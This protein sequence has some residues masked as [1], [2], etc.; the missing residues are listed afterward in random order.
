MRNKPVSQETLDLAKAA[1]LRD[2]PMSQSS[3]GA[4]AGSYLHLV[5][6]DLPLDTPAKA[7]QATYD[8]TPQQIQ[9]AFHTWVR[10][11]DLAQIVFGPHPH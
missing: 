2:Q 4:L 1:I 11:N 10:P 7:A 5:N 9:K 8:M 3:F 6:L